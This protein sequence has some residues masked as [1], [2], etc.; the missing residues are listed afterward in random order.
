[1]IIIIRKKQRYFCQ[2]IAFSKDRIGAYIRIF[3]Q[4][5]IKGSSINLKNL[6]LILKCGSAC[7]FEKAII[8]IL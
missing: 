1:M 2:K 4:K 7:S 8:I 6:F 3:Q 5:R